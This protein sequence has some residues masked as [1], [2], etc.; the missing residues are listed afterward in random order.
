M[1]KKQAGRKENSNDRCN[2][3]RNTHHNLPGYLALNQ[4]LRRRRVILEIFSFVLQSTFLSGFL[5]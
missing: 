2:T 1:P 4:M 3:N 5:A